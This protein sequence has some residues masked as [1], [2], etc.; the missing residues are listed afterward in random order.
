[1]SWKKGRV[2]ISL[3]VLSFFLLA[4]TDASGS[5]TVKPIWDKIL[6]VASL[7]FLGVTE[8]NALI[9]FMRLLVAILVFAV[10]FELGRLTPLGRNT[11]IVVAAI[12]AIMSAIFIPGNLLAGI[13]GA[14]A[15]VVA[16][17]LLGIPVL[18]GFYALMAIPGTSRGMIA[19]RLAVI[20]L[21]LWIL[22]SIKTHA[23]AITG[24]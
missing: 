23:L 20:L 16:F 2:L 4:C 7:Q 3:L 22:I 17:V 8:G 19:L 1:M 24:L 6:N 18:G 11:A 13:G 12:L 21:L 14:Y 9:A 10:L 15:T 5:I